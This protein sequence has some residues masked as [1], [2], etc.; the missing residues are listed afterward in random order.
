MNFTRSTFVNGIRILTAPQH[1]TKA[2]TLLFLVGAGSRFENPTQNGISHFLEH[3]LFKGTEKYPSPQALAETLDG[4]GAAFNAYTSEEYTGFYVQAAAEH[5]LLALDVLH[6]M[7]YHPCY[8]EADIEREKGVII[9]EINMYR[10]LPQRHVWDVLKSLL[11]GDTPLGRNIAGSKETVTS[12]T[13][14]TFVDY[15]KDFYTPDNLILAVA[16]NPA[17]YD[18]QKEIQ[19]LFAQKQGKRIKQFDHVRIISSAPQVRVE[20]RQT[21]QTHLALALPAIKE[22]DERLPIL[23]ILNTILGGSMSSRLF[24]EVREKRGLAY[25]VRSS[26]DTYH[27]TGNLVIATGVRNS[28]AQEAIKVILNELDLLRRKPILPAE[29]KKAQEHFK[30]KLALELESSSE[31]SAFLAQ[32]ELYYRQQFQPEELIAKIE[33]VTTKQVQELAE[34]LF[35][36]S[37]LNLAA[38]GPFE[39]SDFLPILERVFT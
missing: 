29:L 6:Q 10:D 13:H 38:I 4:I 23:A 9:E 27:D 34:E 21:D 17:T 37:R 3:I 39:E 12:F 2:M 15:Q 36:S 33:A 1:E 32:Q 22:T 18:W 35:V 24:N 19:N 20:N 14:T 30:G 5:F 7:F 25:Y 31:I 28:H 16:G 8:A 26:V 11:Y